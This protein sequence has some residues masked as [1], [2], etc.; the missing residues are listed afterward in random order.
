MALMHD[1]AMTSPLKGS[2]DIC[3]VGSA[4]GL[5]MRPLKRLA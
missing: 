2:A 1:H 5:I 3:G 4:A